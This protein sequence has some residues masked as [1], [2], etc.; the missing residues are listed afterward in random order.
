MFAVTPKRFQSSKFKTGIPPCKHS[1]GLTVKEI[2]VTKLVGL[3]AFGHKDRDKNAKQEKGG[4][5]A[6]LFDFFSTHKQ[7]RNS[8]G[9]FEASL[10][11]AS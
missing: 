6:R 7:P 4:L 10:E 2:A 9:A 11:P 8:L 3:A 5:R 1:S